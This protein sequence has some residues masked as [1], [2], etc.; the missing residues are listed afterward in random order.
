MLH[1]RPFDYSDAD[2]AALMAVR[3]AVWPEY[4]TTVP[5]LKHHDQNREPQYLYQR[6]L[7][8]LDG[9]TAAC[10]MYGET[11]WS[12]RPGKYFVDV[13]V[14]PEF[15][16]RGIGGAF[17]RQVQQELADKP[18]TLIEAETREHQDAAL[19]WLEKLGFKQA[20]RLPVS[21]LFLDTF[22]EAPFTDVPAQVAAQGIET[23]SLAQLQEL[24][25]DWARKY[26][27][28][29]WELL[30][31]VPT[32]D[33]LTRQPF[34]EFCKKFNRPSFQ[35]H[36]RFVAVDNTDGSFRWVGLSELTPPPPGHDKYF[37]GLTGVSRSHRRRRIATALKLRAIHYAHS[38]GARIIETD[39]EENNPMLGLN[40]Q[41]GFVAQPAWLI[42]EKH[43]HTAADPHAEQKAVTL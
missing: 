12:Y 41:L 13:M 17:Y 11:P 24:D 7:I 27:D 40:I 32:T 10:A 38:R 30:Q 39:N 3:E 28:L 23:Y 42:F 35:P 29:V 15:R 16:R 6:Y 14:R 21:Y 8:E 22:D 4:P 34:E 33:E 1:I 19:I 31:D 18:L 5:E 37:T 2:Y 26:W 43:F 36:A 25:S 20:M 9:Q